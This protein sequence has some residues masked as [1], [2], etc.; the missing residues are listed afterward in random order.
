MSESSLQNT[1]GT[2]AGI[3]VIDMSRLLPGPY[4]SMILADHGAR[5]IAVESRR[6][7]KEAFFFKTV[8]RNKEHM[9]LDLK[10]KDGRKIFFNLVADADVF[11]EGFRPGVA[12]RL[13]IGYEALSAI[14]S[15]IV[16]CSISGYGQTGPWR[17]RPGHDVNFL[18]TAGVLDMIGEAAGVPAI[19]AVQIADIAGGGMNAVTGILLALFDRT[20]TG[21][22]QHIDISMSDGLLGF[23]MPPLSQLQARGRRPER[24]NSRFSHR[25]AWYNVYQTADDRYI[26]IGALEPRFWKTLCEHLQV[27]EYID[28]QFDEDRRREIIDRLRSVFRA[29]PLSRWKTELDSLEICWSPVQT[30]EEALDDPLFRRR[31]MIRETPAG[32]TIGV[33][34]KL[35]R[36]PG[37]VRTTPPAFGEHTRAILKELGYH[38]DQIED[39]FNRGVV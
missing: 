15:G 37:S 16:Y 10:N 22:G 5:V 26:A 6:F 17:D 11:L 24:G 1:P 4:C 31:D 13:G 34:V 32:R 39:F 7:E 2:L 19:P 35:S 21:R 25:Y 8:Y 33:P 14:N 23:L 20:R 27:P 3:K 12:D 38:A 9:T 36:R 30:M 18:A 29:K 28:L